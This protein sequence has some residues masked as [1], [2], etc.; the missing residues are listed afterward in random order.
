MKKILMILVAVLISSG[1]SA[2]WSRVTG[3]GSVDTYIDLSTVRRDGDKVKLWTMRNYKTPQD[4]QEED[5]HLST[6]E[7]HELDCKEEQR[8]PLF[9]TAYSGEKGTGKVVYN[10]N[11]SNNKWGAI[12]PGTVG[13]GLLEVGCDPTIGSIEWFYIKEVGQ[14]KEALY[15]DYSSIR[16]VG[17][18]ASIVMLY[19]IKGGDF[20]PKEGSYSVKLRREYD[21]VEKQVRT[22]DGWHFSANMGV[23]K[24]DKTRLNP[25]LM[26]SSSG[27]YT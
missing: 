22:I 25:P 21:C 10:I 19:D 15:L 5:K 13:R 9:L 1:A 23:G 8:R 27:K 24:G 2:E 20:T 26:D 6:K 14:E 17:N 12:A 7:Q 18:H 3:S 11:D 4:P 16:K